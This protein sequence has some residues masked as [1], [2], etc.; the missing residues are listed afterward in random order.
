MVLKILNKSGVAISAPLR[1]CT[2][3]PEKL[4]VH[5]PT[6]YFLL[7]PILH[8]SRRP[9]DVPVFHEIFGIRSVLCQLIGKSGRFTFDR[10][11]EIINAEALLST[12]KLVDFFSL[13]VNK[14]FVYTPP[15][16]IEE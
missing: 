12:E 14:G 9:Y 16:A 2:P 15:F 11:S 4:P 6:V 8:P 5:T 10:V 7:Y 1:S 3:C 13:L